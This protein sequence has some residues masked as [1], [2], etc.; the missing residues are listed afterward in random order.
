MIGTSE[1]TMLPFLKKSYRYD[2]IKDFTP[3]A[4]LAT[5]W[6]AFAINPKVRRPRCGAVVYSR[7]HPGGVRYGTAVSAARFTSQSKCFG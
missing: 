5:S 4:L 2:P 6:T 3:V 7:S 1:S